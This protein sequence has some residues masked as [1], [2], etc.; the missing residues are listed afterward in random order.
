MNRVG[1]TAQRLKD[2]LVRVQGNFPTADGSSVKRP[3]RSG[4]L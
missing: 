3:E 4:T 1:M 2:F